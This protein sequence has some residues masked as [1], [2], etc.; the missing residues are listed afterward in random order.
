MSGV[1]RRQYP[2]PV[3]R[4]PGSRF[5]RDKAAHQ[6]G[7]IAAPLKRASIDRS[8]EVRKSGRNRPERLDK[9]FEG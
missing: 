9:A 6:V 2:V 4:V 7:E 5:R 8:E 1:R 3:F